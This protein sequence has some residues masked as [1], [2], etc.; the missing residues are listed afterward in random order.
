M[1][2]K[3]CR[4][5]EEN[6]PFENNKH[7]GT[8]LGSEINCGFENGE[9]VKD[10]WNC[11]TLSILRGICD[12]DSCGY[13]SRDDMWCESI[14]LLKLHRCED[15]DGP[16]GYLILTFYKN[17]GQ[18]GNAIIVCG[19]CKE[20]KLKEEDALKIIEAYGKKG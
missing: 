2:C 11:L 15:N 16:A 3:L 8:N 5:F 13:A 6:H 4:E 1:K 20:E 17:R 12:D 14:N 9:F 18:T 10:N 7:K 19:D